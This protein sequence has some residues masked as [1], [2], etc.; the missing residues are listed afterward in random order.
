L[1]HFSIIAQK[2]LLPMGVSWS[3]PIAIMAV[4]KAVFIRQH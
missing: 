3:F 4:N 1:N 2:L